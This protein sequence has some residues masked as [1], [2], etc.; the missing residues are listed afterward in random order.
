M[1]GAGRKHRA[2]HLTQKY[3]DNLAWEGPKEGESL[4]VCMGPPHANHV[5]VLVL[6]RSSS[7]TPADGANGEVAYTILGPTETHVLLPRKFHKVIW[8]SYRDVIVVA[9]GCV[10]YKPSPSQLATFLKEPANSVWAEYIEKA[11]EEAERRRPDMER[12]PQFDQ[13]NPGGATTTSAL[14]DHPATAPAAEADEAEAEDGSAEEDGD[15]ILGEFVNPNRTNFRH[16]AQFF[17]GEDE[18]EE[19]EEDA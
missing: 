9:D 14:L 7:E 3:L 17:I 4:A 15:D 12:A 2:K 13:R 19:D 18:E 11:K 6:S 10:E 5:R 8:I 1:S 16:R